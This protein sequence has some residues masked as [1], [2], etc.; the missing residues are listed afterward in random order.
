LNTPHR[1]LKSAP[2][3]A[4]AL[5]AC[6]ALPAI[7]QSTAST[8]VYSSPNDIVVKRASDGQLLN[9]TLPA[10]ATISVAGKKVPASAVTAG[11]KLTDALPG[12]PKVVTG[13][14]VEKGK[15]YQVS[16]PDKVTLS[17]TAGVKELTVP[18]GTTFTVGGKPMTLAQ[19]QKGMDVEATI[20]S[21]LGTSDATGNVP[22]D[23]TPAQAGTILLSV[24]TGEPDLP[25]A[26]TN[27]PL[28]GVL[29]FIALML[30][31]ALRSNCF[32]RT[33]A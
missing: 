16:P 9:Y 26:G 24:S 33:N 3:L 21:T 22:P 2:L 29:G 31:L 4:I 32:G 7:A 17:L 15:V 20:V 18:A 10:G 27:L 11:T 25:L 12:D 1:F 19:L 13:I 14:S 23:T 8:V 30:G 6:T 28:Y 5:T